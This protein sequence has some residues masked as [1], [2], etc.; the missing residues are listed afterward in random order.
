MRRTYALLVPILLLAGC[1][2]SGTR[3]CDATAGWEAGVADHRAASRCVDDA[4]YRDSYQLGATVA[5]YRARLERLAREESLLREAGVERDAA[6]ASR[7]QIAIQRELDALIGIATTRG[8]I[9]PHAAAE[10][11]D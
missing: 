8:W 9:P 10:R 6:A 11:G 3:S 1:S 7:Q 2:V 5:E 4:A